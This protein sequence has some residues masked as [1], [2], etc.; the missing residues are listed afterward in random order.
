[1]QV[2]PKF[3]LWSNLRSLS[4]GV[5]NCRAESDVSSDVGNAALAGDLNQ[6]SSYSTDTNQPDGSEVTNG[7]S[8]TAISSDQSTDSS[9]VDAVSKNGS[10]RYYPF[11]PLPANDL[12]IYDKWWCIKAAILCLY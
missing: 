8:N 10:Q 9:P 4:L 12:V 3:A 2:F 7:A 11:Q 5:L 6:Q 1:M